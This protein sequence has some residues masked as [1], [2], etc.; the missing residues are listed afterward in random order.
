MEVTGAVVAAVGSLVEGAE[1]MLS[2]VDKQV[3]RDYDAMQQT[4]F[5]YSDDARYVEELV[6]DLSA[7]TEQ[8]LASIQ[9]MLSAIGE[10]KRH[11]RD[12]GRH[13]RRGRR[14]RQHCIR[15]G[16]DHCPVRQH[17]SGDGADPQRR[18]RASGHGI[19]FQ[20]LMLLRA[21]A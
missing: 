21:P 17:C 9:S 6:T 13:E 18:G 7:T 11:R 20:S 8:L 2:F 16:A 14:S 12:D 5:Q 4:G 1:D 19:A 10:V 15:R 3:M